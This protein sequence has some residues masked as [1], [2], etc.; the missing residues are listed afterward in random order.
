MPFLLGSCCDCSRVGISAPSR[1]FRGLS[2]GALTVG[3]RAVGAGLGAPR[4]CLWRPKSWFQEGSRVGQEQ[5]FFQGPP[6]IGFRVPKVLLSGTP[7]VGL[8]FLQ[9]LVLEVPTSWSQ[10]PARAFV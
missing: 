10:G 8:G 5:E 3:I 2:Q 9:V 6:S 7:I 1:P 4:A